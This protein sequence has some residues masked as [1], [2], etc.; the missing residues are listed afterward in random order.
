M[1]IGAS[2]SRLILLPLYLG[3]RR[4][5][6][7]TCPQAW[8]LCLSLFA[9]NTLAQMFKFLAECAAAEVRMQDGRG[10][11]ESSCLLRLAG[12]VV[13]QRQAVARFQ[14]LR[15]TGLLGTHP[16]PLHVDHELVGVEPCV[17]IGEVAE[18]AVRRMRR[19]PSP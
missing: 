3:S 1:L 16:E 15:G 5:G 17:G 9:S 19:L 14:P 2:G 6:R 4:S 8:I 12:S 11:D 7:S 13:G 18:D 10:V